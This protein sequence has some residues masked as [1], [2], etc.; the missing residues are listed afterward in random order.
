MRHKRHYPSYISDRTFAAVVTDLI[1]ANKSGPISF[2]DLEAGIASMPNSDLKRTLQ[3][4][5]SHSAQDLRSAQ[6]AIE[7]W[8]NDAM[9]R[10]TGWYKRKIQVVTLLVALFLTLVANAD[11][12][13]IGRRL[14]TDPVLRSAVVEEAKTRAQKP[15]PSI[16][17]E[18][19]DENDPTNPTVSRSESSTLSDQERTLLGQLLGWRGSLKENTAQDW[20]ERV[21]GWIL[22]VLAISLGAPFW[23]DLLNKFVNIRSNGKSPAEKPKNPEKEKVP[24]H[25]TSIARPLVVMPEAP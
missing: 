2:N 13:H 14:W 15:R 20:F 7:A 16:S 25:A 11:S 1:T 18:Y 23:F 19:P 5:L 17:V 6:E 22:T 21:L 4:V 8:F 10:V 3:A 24:V 12:I 9:D